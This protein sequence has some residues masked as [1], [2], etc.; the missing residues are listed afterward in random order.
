MSALILLA[1]A[2]FL[3]IIGI[4]AGYMLWGAGWGT[5]VWIGLTALFHQQII[6]SLLLTVG[7]IFMGRTNMT[8]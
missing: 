1:T 8:T 2:L 3:Y 7:F 5:L 4:V 6:M